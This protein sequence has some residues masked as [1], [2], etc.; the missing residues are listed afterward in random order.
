MNTK[1]TLHYLL[2]ILIGASLLI[3]C[4]DNGT[5]VEPPPP[6]AASSDTVTVTDNIT[7]DATWEDGK[8]YILGG[9][10]A[11]EASATLIIEGGAVVKGEAGEQANATAL[12]VARGATLNANGSGGCTHHLYFCCR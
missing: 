3:S 5:G 11:V 8:T 6:P 7:E 4:D 9:R 2:A 1:V 10:I 12:L